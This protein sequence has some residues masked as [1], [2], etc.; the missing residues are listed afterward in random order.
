[1]TLFLWMIL[2]SIFNCCMLMIIIGSLKSIRYVEHSFIALVC[3]YLSRLLMSCFLLLFFQFDGIY[4]LWSQIIIPPL[5]I[6]GDLKTSRRTDMP[7]LHHAS[8]L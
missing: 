4:R 5:K 3:R 8:L 6:Q 7:T 1:M 2:L